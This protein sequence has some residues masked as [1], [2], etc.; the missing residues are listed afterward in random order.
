MKTPKTMAESVMYV[1]RRFRHRLRHAIF[2]RL[3]P[4]IALPSAASHWCR[5]A[6]TGLMRAAL[7]AG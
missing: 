7:R 4:F 1:R 5:M 3:L 2:A 6:S